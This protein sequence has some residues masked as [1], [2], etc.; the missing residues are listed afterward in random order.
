MPLSS[1]IMQFERNYLIIEDDGGA[2]LQN[3][4][5]PLP[6]NTEPHPSQAESSLGLL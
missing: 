3:G 6:N 5:K 1:L 4:R 2:D